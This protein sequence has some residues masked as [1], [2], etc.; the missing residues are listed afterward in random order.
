[1]AQNYNQQG[2]AAGGSGGPINSILALGLTALAAPP[3]FDLTAPFV[4]KILVNHY[5][6]ELADIG[7]FGHVVFVGL[8]TYTGMNRGIAI[9]AT[10]IVTAIGR[11]AWRLAPYA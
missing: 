8:L 3:I 1:M 11:V 9:A 6:E 7:M 10:L 4:H 2:A 5:G